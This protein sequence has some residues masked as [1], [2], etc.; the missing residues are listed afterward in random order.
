[1][2][3]LNPQRRI[4]RPRVLGNDST[5]FLFGVFFTQSLLSHAGDSLNRAWLSEHLLAG[6]SFKV[7]VDIETGGAGG[8]DL[9]FWSLLSC[10][11]LKCYKV[12]FSEAVW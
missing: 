2:V 4:I 1:L 3:F 10:L 5:S 12:L 6:G 11:F 7:R 8:L 9:S